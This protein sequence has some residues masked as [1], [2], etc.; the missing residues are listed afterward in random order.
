MI[1]IVEEAKNKLE[2]E[3]EVPFY[4]SNPLDSLRMKLNNKLDSPKRKFLTNYRRSSSP[5]NS[6]NVVKKSYAFEAEMLESERETLKSALFRKKDE[7][8]SR[9]LSNIIDIEKD[10]L[11]SKDFKESEPNTVQKD[12]LHE[13]SPLKLNKKGKIYINRRNLFFDKDGKNKIFIIFF[14]KFEIALNFIFCMLFRG[15]IP[16]NSQRISQIFAFRIS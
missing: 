12:L 7:I 6:F 5:Y 9:S 3:G 14:L 13:F 2:I 11:S 10:H 8:Q 16:A 1:Q 4:D 15:E